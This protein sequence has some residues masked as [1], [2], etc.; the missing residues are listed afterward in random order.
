MI[1][2]SILT[3]IVAIA[4]PSNHLSSLAR[5][6]AIILIYAGALSFNGLY[7]QS[8]GSGIGL[9]SG[10]FHVTVISQL[11]DLIVFYLGAF[12]LMA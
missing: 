9:Y 1:F 11:F 2:L 8:I 6:S 10:L 4:L 12:I 5:I 7:I 3:L